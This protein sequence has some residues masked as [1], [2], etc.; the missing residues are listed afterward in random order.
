MK[1]S[2]FKNTRRK[3]VIFTDNLCAFDIR[4]TIDLHPWMIP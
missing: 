4:L 2:F 1:S 3:S